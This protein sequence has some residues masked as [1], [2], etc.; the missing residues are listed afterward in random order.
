MPCYSVL[1]KKLTAA[2][3]TGFVVVG[4]GIVTATLY[5]SNHYLDNSQTSKSKVDSC[6]NKGTEHLVVVQNNAA[7]PT[8]TDAKLCDTLTITNKD[9]KV[10][11]MAFGE[12][13]N[14]QP[15]DGVTEKELSQDQSL[16][17]TLNQAGTFQ[18]HDH[19]GDIVQ[20]SFTVN[21]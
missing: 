16:T 2:A 9:D 11:L 12:H 17:V 15:Y 18:F 21:K 4:A 13:E 5:L 3:V 8:H 14:H 20:G 6:P 19:I 1:V 7:N 10:R